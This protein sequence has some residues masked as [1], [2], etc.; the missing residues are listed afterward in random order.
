MRLLIV[1]QK[2]DTRDDLLGFFHQ[3]IREFAKHCELVTVICLEEGVHSLPLNVKIL[4]LGKENSKFQIPNSKFTAR[5]KYIVNFYRYVWGERKNYDAVFVHMNTEYMVLA[6]WLWRL[7]KKKLALWHVHFEVN[8]RLWVAEKFAHVIFTTTPDGCRVKSKKV[9]AIGHGIDV[10][11]FSKQTVVSLWETQERSDLEERSPA[12]AGRSGKRSD[13]AQSFPQGLNL[14]SGK[15]EQLLPQVFQEPIRF[16]YAGKITPIKNVHVLVDAARIL[17]QSWSKKFVVDIVG[18]PTTPDYEKK[19]RGYIVA[20]NLSDIVTMHGRKPYNEMPDF[21][22]R[23]TAVVNMCPTGGMDKT[24]LEGLAS[25]TLAVVAN[26]A[27]RELFGE[28]ADELIYP[29]QNAEALAEKVK[30]LFA[31]SDTE[32]VRMRE[33]LHERMK[34]HS[35]LETRIPVMVNILTTVEV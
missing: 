13:L 24:V 10:T 1:T 4:S 5:F 16:L 7:M 29:Y 2:V 20:K 22:R 6:G 14:F 30:M 12:A 18:P 17:K 27:F 28:Y 32:L 34:A 25:R 21:Y 31:K 19:L 8:W 3:W 9:H 35:S 15:S 23:A 26:T 33:L 11:R